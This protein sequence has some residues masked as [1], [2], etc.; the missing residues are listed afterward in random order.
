M[1]I[2]EYILPE[3]I[4]IKFGHFTKDEVLDNIA[5]MVY[6]RIGT[7]AHTKHEIERKLRER[8]ELGTTGFGNHIAIPHCALSGIEDFVIGMILYTDGADFD[9]MDQKPVKFVVFIIAPEKKKNQHIRY[10]SEVSGVLRQPGALEDIS[11]QLNSVAIR[12]KFLK[13]ALPTSK[14]KKQK[15][16]YALLNIF[17]QDE[18][19]FNEIMDILSVIKDRDISV[20]DGYDAK[21][22]MKKTLFG[23]MWVDATSKFHKL[24]F[25][26]VPSDLAND[27]IR[28]VNNVID[29]MPE[30]KGIMLIMQKIDYISGYLK[31]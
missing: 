2:S 6:N 27:A 12:E 10:L 28:K 22:F 15:E 9:S 26:V 30:R 7:D 1:D 17:C 31:D 18:K 13:Y 19:K 14:D 11:S 5:E 4:E 24:I 23:K 16:E 3:M 21:N 20:Y 25:V 8:E 29:T